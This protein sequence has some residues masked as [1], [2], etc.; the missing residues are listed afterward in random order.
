MFR[1]A[2]DKWGLAFALDCMGDVSGLLDRGEREISFYKEKSLALYRDLGD[3]WALRPN[4][5]NWVTWRYVS[6][7]MRRLRPS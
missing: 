1:A 4:C 2:Q 6:M 7:T 3:R 5:W